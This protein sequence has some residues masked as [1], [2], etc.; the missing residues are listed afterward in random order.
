MCRVG[1]ERREGAWK[2]KET[3]EAGREGR[4]GRESLG[5]RRADDSWGWAAPARTRAA[6]TGLS[7]GGLSAG[8]ASWRQSLP[9]GI[10]TSLFLFLRNQNLLGR[11]KTREPRGRGVPSSIGGIRV[12]F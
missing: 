11:D 12:Y 2:G 5:R 6:L 8:A 10:Q 3:G 9:Q 7:R 4:Q 1:Q